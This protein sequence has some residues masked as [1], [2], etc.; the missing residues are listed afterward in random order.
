MKKIFTLSALILSLSIS[1]LAN[2]KT[3]VINVRQANQQERI[4]EG[5]E[6]GRLTA[7]EATRLE[8][9]EAKIQ[10][11]KIVAKSDGI[12]TTR[13]RVKLKR[14]ENRTSNHIYKAKHN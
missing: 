12:V 7:G 5:I 13:E 14:E 10:H 8:A 3:P 1:T 4:A 2:T 11:D 9:R 6:S